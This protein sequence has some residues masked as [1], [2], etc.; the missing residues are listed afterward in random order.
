MR[1]LHILASDPVLIILNSWAFSGGIYSIAKSTSRELRNVAIKQALKT[2]LDIDL[3]KF[4]L[5]QTAQRQI[6]R[7]GDVFVK[8]RTPEAKA[9]WNRL[10]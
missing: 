2:G 1:E 7:Q 4:R 10:R 6:G 9:S 3:K 5:K 8:I